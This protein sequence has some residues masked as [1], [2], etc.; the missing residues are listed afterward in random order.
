M[1]T[2][3]VKY[4]FSHA[5][6]TIPFVASRFAIVDEMNVIPGAQERGAFADALPRLY[7]DTASAFGDPLLHMLRSVTGLGNVV[8]GTDYPY[9]RDAIS[10]AGLRDS[11]A[12][13][14]SPH[15]QFIPDPRRS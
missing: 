14:R 9:P 13:T 10:I 11:W 1:R 15:F 8:F 3:D 2:P 7:W 12:V 5:G 4:V 6:G